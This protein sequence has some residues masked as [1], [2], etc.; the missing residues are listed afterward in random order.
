[1]RAGEK[2]MAS[3]RAKLAQADGL[4]VLFSADPFEE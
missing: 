4:V 1:V 3:L 2:A